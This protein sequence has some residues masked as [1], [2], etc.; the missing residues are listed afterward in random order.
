MFLYS[1]EISMLVILKYS[2][3]ISFLSKIDLYGNFILI[4]FLVDNNYNI[5]NFYFLKCNLLLLNYDNLLV[6]Y[7]YHV[8][9]LD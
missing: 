7:I 8:C 9:I 6:Y 4:L 1:L 3:G 2:N 5:R